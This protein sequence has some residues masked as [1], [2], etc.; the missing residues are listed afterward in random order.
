MTRKKLDQIID[1]RRFRSAEKERQ[2]SY[3]KIKNK[4]IEKLQ[5]TV[6]SKKEDKQ[7]IINNLERNE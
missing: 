3:K 7:V 5:M 4:S 6:K 1:N 2:S